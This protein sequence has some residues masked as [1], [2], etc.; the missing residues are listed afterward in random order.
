AITLSPG[1]TYYWRV[2]GKTMANITATGPTWSFVTAGSVPP[3]AAPT[4]LAASAISTTRIDL[5]WTD[6]AGEIGY[7]VERSPNGSTGWTEIA[8]LNADE[9]TYSDLSVIAQQTYFYRVRGFNSG[10][11]SPYSSTASATTPAPSAPSGNDIVLWASEAPV[12]VGA[13]SVVADATAAGG[14][15]IFNPDAGAPKIITASAN[16]PNYFEMTFNAQ[17]GT[18]YH[19]WMRGKAQNDFW[20][21][22]SVFVQFNDSVDSGG[23]PVFRIGTTGATEYNLEDCS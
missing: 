16:P 4:G 13:W 20:G 9:V 1:T 15:R 2:V 19:L 5:S 22:D 14:N 12:K 7:R 21:N 10:G 6:T 8:S 17:S 23:N 3:P 18:N 11:F